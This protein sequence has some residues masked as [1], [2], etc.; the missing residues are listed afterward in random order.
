MT[1]FLAVDVKNGLRAAG[2]NT[3]G[4]G[5]PVIDAVG[6]NLPFTRSIG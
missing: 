3:G 6:P 2:R 1:K 4:F 5:K